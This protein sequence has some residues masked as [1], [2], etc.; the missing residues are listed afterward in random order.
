M[1]QRSKKPNTTDGAVR[2]SL[3]VGLGLFDL[4]RAKV[5][6]YLAG[7]KKDLPAQARKKAADN[8]IKS[9]KSNSKKLE[10]STRT[11]IK[12]ALDAMSSKIDPH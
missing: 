8:F 11:Q 9:I 7:L 1:Q 5:E 6:R 10:H 2:Q 12:S 4:S 3:L